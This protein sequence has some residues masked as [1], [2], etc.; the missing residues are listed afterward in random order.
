MGSLNLI[1]DTIN[2]CQYGK[3]F[4][5]SLKVSDRLLNAELFLETLLLD[6]SVMVE[7]KAVVGLELSFP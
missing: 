3:S 7:E 1:N 2:N 4:M 6:D 5:V